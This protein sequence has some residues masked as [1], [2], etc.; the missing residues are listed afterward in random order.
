[1]GTTT[2][3]APGLS[4]KLKKVLE[5]RI[6]N[7]DLM[8]AFHSEINSF[9]GYYFLPEFCKDV[10]V[11][12]IKECHYMRELNISVSLVENYFNGVSP[13]DGGRDVVLMDTDDFLPDDILRTNPLLYGASDSW[14]MPVSFISVIL[15]PIVGNAAEHASAIMFAMKDKLLSDI[16]LGV[17][18][19]SSTHISMFVPK[20]MGLESNPIRTRRDHMKNTQLTDSI[21]FERLFVDSLDADVGI[22]AFTV[23]VK[24]EIELLR[25]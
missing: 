11:K 10:A 23:T 21:Y 9:E 24:V 1:M 5:T 20:K 19:G 8:A 16:T 18:I 13:D 14:N 25:I 22:D 15:L 3:L 4:R 6:D 7:P 12:Y 17:A 2:A